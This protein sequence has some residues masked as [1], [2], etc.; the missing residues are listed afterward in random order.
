[1]KTHF[2]TVEPSQSAYSWRGQILGMVIA[3][4]LT[5]SIGACTTTMYAGAR[6]PSAEIAVISSGG[7]TTLASID[8]IPVDGG[9]TGSY[10]VLPGEHLVR[11]QGRESQFMGFYTR[12]YTSRPLTLCFAANPG[13][14][15]QLSCQRRDGWYAEII[16]SATFQPVAIGCPKMLAQLQQ[17][18]EALRAS[19]SAASVQGPAYQLDPFEPSPASAAQLNSG[20]DAPASQSVPTTPAPPPRAPTLATPLASLMTDGQGAVLPQAPRPGTGF[21]LALGLAGGG[22][23]LVT[24][25][26]SNGDSGTLTAGG[27][28]YLAVGATVTPLWIGNAVG[29]GLGGDIGWKY[30]SLSASNGSVDMSRFPLD[31]WVQTLIAFTDNWYLHVLAGPHKESGVNLS[32]SGVVTGGADFDSPWGWMAQAGFYT[33]T[34]WHVA[35]AFGLRYT[36]VHYTFAGQT[37]D[38][39]NIGLDLTLHANL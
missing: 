2:G 11:L 26:F 12:V 38:A 18:R 37:I 4:L 36:G 33:T 30:D 10:E 17:R 29:L 24:A 28:V 20:P 14:R 23:N 3:V 25:Q 1:M 31:L 6:R 35:C 27:G 8:G 16:D 13:H 5:I 34:S 19:R 32:G 22:D 9:S 21:H 39:S 15:Y 7:G